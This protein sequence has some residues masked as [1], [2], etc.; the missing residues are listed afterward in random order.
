[1]QCSILAT[2]LGL[3]VTSIA[4]AVPDDASTLSKKA[5]T[6]IIVR[7]CND[8]HGGKPCETHDVKPRQCSK[9]FH[10]YTQPTS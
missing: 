1:M 10:P 2:L 9:F 7:L 3:A 6:G 8:F 4:V 5:A